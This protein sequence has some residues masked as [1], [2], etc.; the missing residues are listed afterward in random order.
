MANKN[1]EA[2]FHDVLQQLFGALQEDINVAK[3]ARVVSYSS[4]SHKADVQPLGLDSDGDKLGMIH[5]A[6]VV[7][8][9]RSGLSAGD[10][11]LL[12]FVDGD[13]DNFTGSGTFVKASERKHDLNDAVVLGVI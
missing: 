13:M 10:T 9:A 6:Q 11:V 2:A 7:K 1:T 3:W 4:S 12:V 8:S 5:D